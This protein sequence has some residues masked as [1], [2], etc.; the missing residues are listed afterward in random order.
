MLV[1]DEVSWLLAWEGRAPRESAVP[2]EPERD[3]E[4][5][6]R[7]TWAAI[8][9]ACEAGLSD[10]GYPPDRRAALY[11]LLGPAR[12][13]AEP[14]ALRRVRLAHQQAAR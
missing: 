12:E 6:F 8:R 7:R 2:E 13:C 9:D 4:M 11:A 3:A 10:R 14:G 5:V 1:M